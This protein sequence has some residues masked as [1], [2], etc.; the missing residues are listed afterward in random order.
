MQ[1]A[2]RTSRTAVILNKG[3]GALRSS[4]PAVV[5]AHI[6]QMFIAAGHETIVTF[7]DGPQLK[8][9][10]AQHIESRDVGTIV[11][12]G[13]DGTASTSAALLVGSGIALGVLPLGT[14]NFFARA[15]QIPLE[16]D[17]AIATLAKAEEKLIDVGCV[18]ERVFLHQVSFGLQPKLIKV[19]DKMEYGSRLGKMWASVRAFLF[20]LRRPPRLAL[21]ASFE[22]KRKILDT[23]AL[24]ISNNLYGD[25]HLPFPDRLDEGLLGIYA[26]TST[27]WTEIAKLAADVVLGNHWTNNPILEMHQAHEITVVRAYNKSRPLLASIDGELVSLRGNVRIESN[28][29]SLKVLIPRKDGGYSDNRKGSEQAADQASPELGPAKFRV[30]P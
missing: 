19:R 7:C 23:P 27:D 21:E 25:S 17:D 13:G 8:G 1:N 30:A 2:S 6:E 26:C 28:A 11:V 4:D 14:M 10:V 20:A 5:K 16:L 18:D 29:R 12:G 15:L 22:G 24:V 3:A 9:I